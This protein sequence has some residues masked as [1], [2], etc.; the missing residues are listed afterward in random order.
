MSG[1]DQFLRGGLFGPTAVAY[2]D[3]EQ[4]PHSQVSMTA[5][6]FQ[7]DNGLVNCCRQAQNTRCIESWSV[8]GLPSVWVMRPRLV[9]GARTVILVMAFPVL[10]GL[11]RLV[12][13]LGPSKSG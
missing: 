9:E 10:V 8:R 3:D 5:K 4:K 1:F 6:P 11:D 7:T 12:L 13:W 2:A